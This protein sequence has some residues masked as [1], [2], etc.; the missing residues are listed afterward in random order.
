MCFAWLEYVIA[1]C[2]LHTCTVSCQI[3]HLD[4]NF[5]KL[6]DDNLLNSCQRSAC[7]LILFIAL[8]KSFLFLLLCP[9]PRVNDCFGQRTCSSYYRKIYLFLLDQQKMCTPC[10]GAYRV[11]IYNEYTQNTFWG[12]DQWSFHGLECRFQH[13]SNEYHN[14]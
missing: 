14:F 1:V 7:A 12:E 3:Q 8:K 5:L 10:C 9:S 13:N 6:K 11:E 4:Q 2:V